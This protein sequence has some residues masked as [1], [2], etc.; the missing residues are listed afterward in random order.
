MNG[1]PNTEQEFFQSFIT[2]LHS[3][4]D[5]QCLLN[6][7]RSIRFGCGKLSSVNEA[8]SETVTQENIPFSLTDHK[9]YAK[10]REI[11]TSQAHQPDNCSELLG[12]E[13]KGGC[14]KACRLF[15]SAPGEA[16]QINHAFTQLCNDFQ[17]FFSEMEIRKNENTQRLF[18][19]NLAL[20]F[21]TK[22]GAL[23]QQPRQGL[24]PKV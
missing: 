5:V 14:S 8:L 19:L 12:V 10:R 23:L 16:V 4:S 7:P 15:S 9:L 11:S 1:F 2:L 21:F 18:E 3:I 6:A 24:Y 17:S 20:V 22:S 13:S